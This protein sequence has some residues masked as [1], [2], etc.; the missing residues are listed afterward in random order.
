MT[1]VEYVVAAV[2]VADA[3]ADADVKL[4]HWRMDYHMLLQCYHFSSLR[5][6]HPLAKVSMWILMVSGLLCLKLQLQL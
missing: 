2:A 1:S 4:M 5:S 6:C 3:D